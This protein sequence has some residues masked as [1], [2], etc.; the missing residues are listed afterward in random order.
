M[1]FNI[2]NFEESFTESKLKKGLVL[3]KNGFIEQ[4]L[5]EKTF[6]IEHKNNY[7]TV[8]FY[9]KGNIVNLNCN[10]GE[11]KCIHIIS[12]LFYF[13]KKNL[14]IEIKPKIKK[15]PK[16]NLISN[17][18]T[19]I[20]ELLQNE[21]KTTLI[22]LISDF[23]K[24]NDI[25]NTKLIATFGS[26]AQFKNNELLFFKISNTFN[27]VKND[28]IDFENLSQS[29]F[30]LHQSFYTQSK[31]E[32]I[33]NSILNLQN[34]F[35]KNNTSKY[36]QK[37][38][39]DFYGN[40]FLQT[41]SYKEFE[42]TKLPINLIIK[43]YFKINKNEPNKLLPQYIIKLLWALNKNDLIEIVKIIENNSL[44][45]NQNQSL[46]VESINSNISKIIQKVKNE[47]NK[48]ITVNENINNVFYCITLFEYDIK[49]AEE[50]LL[51]TLNSNPNLIFSHYQFS[52]SI[53]ISLNQYK[54]NNTLN[55][56]IKQ[57]FISTCSFEN[58]YLIKFKELN[59]ANLSTEITTIFN[60]CVLKV[61]GQQITELFNFV[62]YFN[63]YPLCFKLIQTHQIS[64]NLI[65]QFLN[66]TKFIYFEDIKLTYISSINSRINELNTIRSQELIFNEIYNSLNLIPQHKRNEFFEMLYKSR[67]STKYFHKLIEKEITEITH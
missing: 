21:N 18:K 6:K 2:H 56:F 26:T 57:K 61:K 11:N 28:E 7:Y 39:I 34:Y 54:L 30:K 9:Q 12:C 59:K 15:A 48:K 24:K 3:L 43:Q 8:N 40:K 45:Q 29:I 27:E 13:N 52:N 22:K 63:Q 66:N 67:A 20:S 62:L 31:I 53:F 25:I 51:K 4:N 10:C 23:A 33:I 32:F 37:D 35:I 1:K 64:F 36:W 49:L 16:Q 60:Y 65:T 41:I 47:K 58:N 38:F 55:I 42:K 17:N 50:L 5:L 46:A 19:S 44:N 14:S